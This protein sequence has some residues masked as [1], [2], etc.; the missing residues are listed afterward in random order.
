[1]FNVWTCL[2]HFPMYSIFFLL[3]CYS[4]VIDAAQFMQW[5]IFE[6]EG[7]KRT[8]TNIIINCTVA[9]Y[10]FY[11]LVSHKSNVNGIR[12]W[13]F[14]WAHLM[15]IELLLRTNI[16]LWIEYSHVSEFV[17]V[18]VSIILFCFLNLTCKQNEL[19]YYYVIYIL[20]AV[21]GHQQTNLHNT[22]VWAVRFGYKM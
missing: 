15:P 16:E 1:M 2:F 3:L 9:K 19:D 21:F 22:H 10:I 5:N 6:I 7:I 4:A 17:C 12:L 18:C 14:K 20:Y 13:P 11:P 8:K